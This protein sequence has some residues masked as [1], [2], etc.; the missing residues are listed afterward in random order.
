MNFS[1]AI[2]KVN[3]LYQG[4]KFAEAEDLCRQILQRDPAVHG[5]LYMMGAMLLRRGEVDGAADLLGRAVNLAPAIPVYQ[6]AYGTALVSQRK[7]SEAAEAYRR[8]LRDSP[9]LASAHRGLGRALM[10]MGELEL[11]M[12][13]LQKGLELGAPRAETLGDMATVHWRQGRMVQALE[14]ARES[15]ALQPKFAW[16]HNVLGL[17]QAD[18]GDYESAMISFQ[19]AI[20]LRPEMSEA[21]NNLANS[22]RATGQFSKAVE[23]L[24]SL[25]KRS[26][27][28]AAG[29][30]NLGVVLAEVGEI[31]AAIAVY[32]QALER[33]SNDPATHSNFLHCLNFS[34]KLS[35]AAVAGEH[36]RWGI[37]HGNRGQGQPWSVRHIKPDQPLRV[38]YLT[39]DLWRHPVSFFF[40]PL[41][42]NHDPS[43]VDAFVY[44]DVQRPDETTARLKRLAPHWTDVAGNSHELLEKVIRSDHLDILVD[45]G[46]HT[47]HNRLQVFARKPAPVQMTYLGYPNTTGLVTMDYRLT[48]AI[49][50][51]P[52]SE[53][54]YTEK[55]LRLP[56]CFLCYAPPA[57][58]P[59]LVRTALQQSIT[60]GSLNRMAKL[61]DAMIVL[62]AQIL[63][64]TPHSRLMLKDAIFLD[65]QI[66]N[67][68]RSRLEKFG[69]DP[70][71]VTLECPRMQHA[72][73]LALYNSIDIALDTFPYNG[74]TT[75][76]EALWMGV[77][78]IT[79]AGEVHASRVS[80][81]IL[82]AI[83][84]AELAAHSPEEYVQLAVNLAGDPTRRARLHENLRGD[85]ARSPLIDGKTFARSVEAAYRQMWADR[86][87]QT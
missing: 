5:A 87:A 37:N 62:W 69:I 9:R 84:H 3:E 38:G 34:A 11:A 19:K 70:R 57:N 78:V 27:G 85:M 20:T 29:H 43:V 32:G 36:R 40:E 26:P 10:Q 8:A 4:G 75:T 61:T 80:L 1:Q 2:Q 16:G 50:D 23:T 81:S 58:S 67:V 72:D 86:A 12:Q 7:F 73:H 83:G 44:S 25:T 63:A 74:T 59:L 22:Y 68:L 21:H 76:C 35:R 6:S 24:W 77:P 49:A 55:L 60:F 47:E 17:V 15:I 33:N 52:G 45:L 28:Y 30:A 48:D 79:L 46:G 56:D 42:K 14:L 65:R 64:A 66:C 51:P 39:A 82:T 31:D 71:C 18:Q 53:A 54:W 41:L 13:S